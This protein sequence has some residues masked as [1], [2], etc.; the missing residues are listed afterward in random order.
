MS[1]SRRRRSFIKPLAVVAGAVAAVTVASILAT[2]WGDT[3][4]KAGTP[5]TV[6]ADPLSTWQT[7]GT[8][9]SLAQ[10]GNT[11]YAGGN[12]DYVRPPGTVAGVSAELG[13]S[14]LAAFDVAT[15][16]PT[17]FAH[18]VTGTAYISKT[19]P[20]PECE[21]LGT[22][23]YLCD[24]I[25][26]AKTSPD[27]NELYFGGDFTHV[28]GQIRARIAGIDLTTG[29]LDTRMAPVVNN[30]IRG[31]AVS[32]TT[33]YIGGD[34]S[35][36]NGQPRSRLAALDRATGALLP[37]A[38]TA[39]DTVRA[40]ALSSDGS[41][42]I[43]GG[44]FPKLNGSNE[45]SVGAVSATGTG[46]L[47][48]WNSRPVPA[49]SGTKFSGVTDLV[50]SGATVYGGA[51]GE[52]GG[53]FD[54]RFAVDTNTGNTL[55]KNTCLGATTT[56]AVQSSSQGD[57]VY[58]GSHGH[59][60]STMGAWAQTNPPT[61]QRLQAETAGSGGKSTI[62]HW[63]PY[64]NYGTEASFYKQGPWAMVANS[65]YLWVGG[66]FTRAGNAD[67]QG[68]TR[69]AVKSVA[70]DSNPPETPFAAATVAAVGTTALKVSWKATWDRD[71]ADL[72]YQV[73][74]D[75]GTTPIYTTTATSNF[76]TLPIL[77]FTDSGLAAQ[78]SHYY[79]VK[80]SDPYRNI[81]SNP[82]SAAVPA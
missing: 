46:A 32:A 59:D 7:D 12:F 76:W 67:Q 22:D 41:R 62:L 52:G 53:V 75:N 16:N 4:P 50:V 47:T 77:T 3:A 70:A 30:R 29:K 26:R 60:C 71:N 55:W 38:P 66:E 37:W 48:Q 18:A 35:T 56:I 9:W 2:A 20:G 6:T 36:V 33:L 42:V 51:H 72:T 39:G 64:V 14:N 61:Y 23:E 54:G 31:I 65:S 10:S 82:N 74:R 45:N 80:V 13:R 81:R 1:R 15:G 78:S 28:D 44:D 5:E 63:F 24:A 11:V 57:T 43:I 40:L 21:T 34:F 27:G 8:V 73:F 19:S 68:L 25:F 69:F 58:S 49:P 17:S 79:R